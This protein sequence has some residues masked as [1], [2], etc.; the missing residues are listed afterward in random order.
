MRQ[1]VFNP[2]KVNNYSSLFNC[3][4]VG[5]A[6][7]SMMARLILYFYLKLF[8][9]V[10]WSRN[11]FVCCL[12]HR[13][14]NGDPLLLKTISGVVSPVARQHFASVESS[15]MILHGTLCDSLF[16]T[17]EVEGEVGIP[18]SQIK[19]P[20]IF[21]VTG[22]SKAVLLIWLFMFTCFGVSFCTVFTFY[23]SYSVRFK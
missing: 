18:L 19:S 2:I 1:S 3:T 5:R 11:F 15:C 6:S 9:L 7:Y 20:V 10:G 22:R 14:A 16:T 4:P 21:Y 17:S 8:I 12:A 23:V 13:C